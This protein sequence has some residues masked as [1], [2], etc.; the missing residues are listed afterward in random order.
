MKIRY[1]IV[2][3][4]TFCSVACYDDLGNYDYQEINEIRIIGM[5]DNYSAFTGFTTL[6][7]VPE[8]DFSLDSL[9]AGR[10]EYRWYVVNSNFTAHEAPITISDRRNLNYRVELPKAAY[11]LVFDILDRETG[12]EWSKT[13]VLDV[14]TL[15]TNGWLLLGERDGFAS[16]DMV[17]ISATD[18]TVVTDVLKNSGLPALK[19]PRKMFSVNYPDNKNWPWVNGCFMLTDDGMYELDRETFASG[20][21]MN[22]RY[23]MYDPDI[24]NSFAPSDLV[25]YN[26]FSR[27]MIADSLL[28][29]NSYL[30]TAGGFGVPISR[31]EQG[32]KTFKVWP[33]LIYAKT[34]A[35]TYEYNGYQM[36]YNVEAKRFVQFRA[37]HFVCQNLPDNAGDPFAWETGND[38]VAVFN[39]GLKTG[40]IAVSYA[41]MKSPD[42]RYYLYSLTTGNRSS[43]PK[44]GKRYD[45]TSLPEIDRASQFVFSANYPYMLYAAGAQLY[46]CEFLDSGI[47]SQI[48]PGFNTDEITMLHFETTREAGEEVFYVATYNRETGG[49]VQKYKLADDPNEIRIEKV[50]NSRWTHLGKITSMCWKWY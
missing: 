12:V 24:Q 28:Y 22:F 26:S 20:A 50:E 10:F 45:I 8:L 46:A 15:Y 2:C 42:S 30:S 27:L 36:A 17:T 19:G 5:Q 11:Y 18:T 1:W 16:L 49:T 34:T 23:Y 25:Q 39:S 35:G 48:L 44:K 41:I 32:G 47:T 38:M 33:Q 31:Y 43:S 29:A 3:L 37:D 14:T 9:P 13:S 21:G 6:N 7:I 40:G 4:F